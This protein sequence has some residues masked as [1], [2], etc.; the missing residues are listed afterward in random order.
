MRPGND[1][2]VAAENRAPDQRSIAIGV[3]DFNFAARDRRCLIGD[4]FCHESGP[5]PARSAAERIDRQPDSFCLD[6]GIYF[7]PCNL[8]G[9][10]RVPCPFGKP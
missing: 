8:P 5:Q 9:N 3:D 2:A 4:T 1:D 6:R 10:H 7:E